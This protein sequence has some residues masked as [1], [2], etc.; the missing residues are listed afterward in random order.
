MDDLLKEPSGMFENFCRMSLQDFEYLLRQIEPI[1]SKR[2][3]SFRNSVPAKIRL[4]IT[5]R[6]LATG[7]SYKS[8]YYLFKVSS[9]LISAIV[10]EVCSALINVLKDLVK[11]FIILFKKCELYK[12]NYPFFTR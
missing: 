11:V 2:N 1:I 4:A 3:T 7:D 9:Q 5:L 12:C 6:F 10:P 8:L